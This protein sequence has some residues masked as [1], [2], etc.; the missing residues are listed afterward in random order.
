MKRNYRFKRKEIK[1][2]GLFTG[3]LV[4]MLLAGCGSS[5]KSDEKDV[6]KELVRQADQSVEAAGPLTTNI[7]E[8]I[9]NKVTTETTGET[10]KE[11]ET[12]TIPETTE[13]VTEKST[14]QDKE[15]GEMKEAAVRYIQNFTEQEKSMYR[16][17]T[18]FDYDMDG[19]P[20]M[21]LMMVGGSGNRV[22]DVYRY[23]EGSFVMMTTA[24]IGDVQLENAYD[25][26]RGENNHWF[27]IITNV[28]THGG[29]VDVGVSKYDLQTKE[30]TQLG[31]E[32]V[33]MSGQDDKS[34]YKNAQGEIISEEE[35][36]EIMKEATD[37]YAQVEYQAKEVSV[38][39]SDIRKDVEEAFEA[40]RI[41]E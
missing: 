31:Y 38:N 11:E 40:Y 33:T 9:K 24:E 41:M 5:G 18:F 20:E 13:A 23:Q 4:S 25:V 15:R 14:E 2:R 22:A 12:K 7:D 37:G 16:L 17:L 6:P 28:W 36:T 10:K 26:Y 19:I 32:A 21:F 3:L 39:S 1:L 8:K 27:F 30:T 35:F 34:E 29:G